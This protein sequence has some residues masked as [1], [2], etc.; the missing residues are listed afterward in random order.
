M[1]PLR[2]IAKS[3]LAIRQ[4]IVPRR[5]FRRG[6]GNISAPPKNCITTKQMIMMGAV[7]IL[8][9]WTYPVYILGRIK[10]DYEKQ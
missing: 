10:K 3:A 4:V 1:I 5:S 8:G 9:M 7:M 6:D 2:C